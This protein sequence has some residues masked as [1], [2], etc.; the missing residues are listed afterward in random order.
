MIQCMIYKL[1]LY[2]HI[3]ENE[4]SCVLTILP[5]YKAVIS[6]TIS[7]MSLNAEICLQKHLQPKHYAVRERER[8][9]GKG[10]ETF[11]HSDSP[12]A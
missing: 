7:S 6:F 2:I 10:K 12:A 4:V 3:L 8:E 5:N 1:R 11:K 9:L